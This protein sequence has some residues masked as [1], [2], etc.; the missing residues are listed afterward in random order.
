M[1]SRYCW[2]AGLSVGLL[3]RAR[4]DCAEVDVVGEAVRRSTA[5]K[6]LVVEVRVD[7]PDGLVADLVGGVE[8]VLEVRVRA[9]RRSR[10]SRRRSPSASGRTA[11]S[12]THPGCCTPGRSRRNVPAELRVRR[13]TTL[14]LRVDGGRV[15][16][17]DHR[18]LLR[19]ARGTAPAS[20]PPARGDRVVGRDRE[21]APTSAGPLANCGAHGEAGHRR[22]AAAPTGRPPGRRRARSPGRR[23][24]SR[25][26]H[27][28]VMALLTSRILASW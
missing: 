22:E 8:H 23:G 1:M 4:S 25:L 16:A 13:L 26:A 21:A 10:R 24:R 27:A 20:W 12:R 19:P 18:G 3:E 2:V 15:V 7:V 6:R 17:V 14:S 11:S 5:A 9:A 28:S